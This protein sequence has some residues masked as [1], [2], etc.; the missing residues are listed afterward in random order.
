MEQ[1]IAEIEAGNI[2]TVICKDLSRVGREYL[3]V[4][5]YTEMFFP[6]VSLQVI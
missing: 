1:M 5:H 2:S 6:S 4:G 3:Q